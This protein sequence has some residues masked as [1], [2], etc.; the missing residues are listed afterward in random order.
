MMLSKSCFRSEMCVMLSPFAAVCSQAAL[1]AAAGVLPAFCCHARWHFIMLLVLLMLNCS[2]AICNENLHA[3]WVATAGVGRQ[4]PKVLH[5]GMIVR[6][7]TGG[8]SV[9]ACVK[10]AM[11]RSPRSPRL[12]TH[13]TEQ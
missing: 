4:Q 11:Q 5:R 13:I 6:S 12:P 3:P 9:S 2:Y 10:V 1:T 8:Y 7:I